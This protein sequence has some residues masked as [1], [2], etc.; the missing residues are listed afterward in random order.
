MQELFRDMTLKSDVNIKSEKLPVIGKRP[1]FFCAVFILAGILFADFAN[2]KPLYSFIACGICLVI[3][4]FFREVPNSACMLLFALMFAAMT[5]FSLYVALPIS[6]FDELGTVDIKGRII[7]TD[8]KNEDTQTFLLSDVTINDIPI[9]KNI[10][11]TTQTKGYELDDIIY[12]SGELRLPTVNDG[13]F[14]YER[15]CMSKNAAYTCLSY[16]TGYADH[17]EDVLSAVNS[18]R[19][20]AA[21]KI[22]DLYGEDAAIVKAFTIGMDEDIESE[23]YEGYR[24]TGISHILVISGLHVG[25]VYM[26]LDAVL[27]KF[28]AGRKLRF[29]CNIISII[30]IIALSG[31]SL[32]AIRAGIMCITNISGRFLGKKNDT[33]TALSIPFILSVIINPA[34]VFSVSLQLSY[35]AVFGILVFSSIL[36]NKLSFIKSSISSS[37]GATVGTFPIIFNMNGS[38]YLPSVIVNIFIV[39][40]CSIV[41]PLTMLITIIYMIFGGITAYLA[42]PVRIMITALNGVSK[43]GMISDWGYIDGGA[44]SGMGIL[45]IYT[46][47]FIASKYITASKKTKAAAVIIF[48]AVFIAACFVPLVGNASEDS[49]LTVVDIGNGDFDILKSDGKYLVIDTGSNEKLALQYLKRNNITPDMILLTSPKENKLSGLGAL[50]SEYPNATVI[51]KSAVMDNVK[52]SFKIEQAPD[53]IQFGEL[54]IYL[55]DKDK[56]TRITIKRGEESVVLLEEG[57]ESIPQTDIIKLYS[58]GKRQKYTAKDVYYSNAQYAVISSNSKI[59]R[60]TEDLLKGLT[61]LNTYENGSVVITFSDKLE[62]ESKYESG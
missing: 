45:L 56:D 26:A 31:F 29:S 30:S 60:D 57:A 13:A 21:D 22:E 2:V 58:N 48:S 11:L 37:F 51:A 62:V 23:L 50:L 36:G 47:I 14:D 28:R 49:A 24:A 39:P 38:F 27:R 42:I 59:S 3:Y 16:D 40:F 9:N 54:E 4:V 61:V 17:A 8:G 34:A 25:M 46:I 1:L 33:L 43:I 7:E 15:Y 41:I 19:Y 55:E 32:S 20:S 10:Y 53:V 6:N 12:A 44:I 35:A 18:V 52:A 5:Y